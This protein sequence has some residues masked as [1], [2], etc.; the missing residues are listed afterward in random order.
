[1]PWKTSVFRFKVLVKSYFWFLNDLNTSERDFKAEIM[2]RMIAKV[3]VSQKNDVGILF[4][5]APS[6]TE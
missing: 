3:E 1:M 4:I 5:C 6:N 2:S